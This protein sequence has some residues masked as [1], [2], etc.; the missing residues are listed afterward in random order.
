MKLISAFFTVKTIDEH[1]GLPS[2]A[3]DGIIAA[4]I[5]LCALIVI[6]VA[7]AKRRRSRSAGLFKIDVQ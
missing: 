3:L 4:L 2:G 7:I 5:C 1:K 6:I